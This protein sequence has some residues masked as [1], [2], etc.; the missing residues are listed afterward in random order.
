MRELFIRMMMVSVFVLVPSM[1]VASAGPEGGLIVA[2]QTDA[3][4]KIDGELDEWKLGLFNDEQKIALTRK[5]GF[6]NAGTIDDDADFSTIV[7]A[8]YDK[9]NLYLAAEVK[10]DATEKGYGGNNNWQNDWDVSFSKRIKVTLFGF[11]Q[12]LQ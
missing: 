7:Y 3:N 10:D 2:P 12:T 9:D 8:L 5:N 6:I 11:R 1:Q 4:I